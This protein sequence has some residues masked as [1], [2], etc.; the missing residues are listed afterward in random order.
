MAFVEHVSGI[1]S[2]AV[3]VAEADLM[4]AHE[5]RLLA[6]LLTRVPDSETIALLK[7]LRGDMSPLGIAHIALAEAATAAQPHD[8]DREFFQLFLGVGRGE[9]VPYASYY[10]TGFLQERPL[11]E[12][13]GD[14][15]LYGIAR[16]ETLREPEDHIG[17]LCEVM[18]GLIE[19]RFDAEPG[20]D[21]AF[22]RRHIQ[23]WAS[24]FFADLETAK[25]A[26]F[27]RHVGAIGRMF[28]EIEAEAEAFA[29]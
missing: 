20:A 26:R 14:L 4:R 6:V 13:R 25:E 22:F 18:A 24:R 7:D 1:G 12:I 9:L 27:Y 28:M 3:E 19:N 29:D 17:I 23:P 8:L 21:R 10:L 5:Y 2:P 16:A 15:R 11:A